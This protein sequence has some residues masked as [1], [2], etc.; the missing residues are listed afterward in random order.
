MILT[1]LL[2]DDA[3]LARLIDEIEAVRLPDVG[4]DDLLLAAARTYGAALAALIWD[5]GQQRI[6]DATLRHHL[7][8]LPALALTLALALARGLDEFDVAIERCLDVGPPEAGYD[9]ARERLGLSVS[10]CDPVVRQHACAA[11]AVG[12]ERVKTWLVETAA[13]SVQTDAAIDAEI[14]DFAPT[15]DLRAIVAMAKVDRDEDERYSDGDVA[16]YAVSVI[17]R[18]L[19]YTWI[20][21]LSPIDGVVYAYDW[22]SI[23]RVGLALVSPP[24]IVKIIDRIGEQA[25]VARL[26]GDTRVWHVNDALGALFDLLE[27]DESMRERL[28][29]I[30]YRASEHYVAKKQGE[31]HA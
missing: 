20:T 30:I 27:S 9:D 21:G 14:N 13:Q 4:D 26:A 15:R 22:R 23:A 25:A 2:R 10:E 31:T 17:E 28:A 7:H 11:I 16:G 18:V 24:T 8:E 6:S 3:V 12:A 5:L 19:A 1:K 29:S